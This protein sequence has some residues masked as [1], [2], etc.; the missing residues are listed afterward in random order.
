M[1]VRYWR[2]KECEM[3]WITKDVLVQLIC[4]FCGCFGTAELIKEKIVKG[5]YHGAKKK[6][7]GGEGHS[8][9][10]LD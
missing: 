4:P 10:G 8:I 5:V 1:I 6:D 2:C 3:G 7:S 9:S